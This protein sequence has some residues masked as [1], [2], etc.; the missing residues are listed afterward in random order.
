FLDLADSAVEE[1]LK[2]TSESKYS[3][4]DVLIPTNEELIA[5]PTL[6]SVS[7]TVGGTTITGSG[8]GPLFDSIVPQDTASDVLPENIT[9]EQETI[10]L[11]TG[12]G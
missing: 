3:P 7:G 4:S 6:V 2:G 10:N 12:D 11:N 5:N 1:L 8:V 9:L